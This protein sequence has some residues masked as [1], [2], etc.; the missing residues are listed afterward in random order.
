[1]ISFAPCTSTL[2]YFPLQPLLPSWYKNGEGE[3][4]LVIV[5]KE[6]VLRI[7]RLLLVSALCSM[8]GRES[9]LRVRPNSM[10]I[11]SVQ[12]HAEEMLYSSIFFPKVQSLSHSSS[13]SLPITFPSCCNSSQNSLLF[14]VGLSRC[15]PKETQP[16]T[17]KA[18]LPSSHLLFVSCPC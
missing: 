4:E 7:R 5:A 17:T 15:W 16:S 10:C 6:Y 18:Q 13:C 1:M 11:D 3:K 2:L 8:Q 14:S 9:A 12:P